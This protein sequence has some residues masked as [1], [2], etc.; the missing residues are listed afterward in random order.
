MLTNLILIQAGT[1][2]VSSMVTTVSI[3]KAKHQQRKCKEIS[4]KGVN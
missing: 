4:I 1:V 3:L 2:I